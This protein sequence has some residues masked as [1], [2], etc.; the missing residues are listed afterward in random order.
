MTRLVIVA[1]LSAVSALAA[2]TG[3]DTGNPPVIDFGN[4]GC[5]KGITSALQSVD[6]AT[7]DP[8]YEGLTCLTWQHVDEQTV[9]VDLT[10]YESGCHSDTGWTPRTKLREDGGLDLILQDAECSQAGC[11]W[12]IYDLSFTVALDQS[13][14]DGEV[15]V[16]QAG[17]DGVSPHEK[18]AVLALSSQ[19]SGAVCNYANRNALAWPG[20]GV[21]GG[22]RMPCATGSAAGQQ[23]VSCQAGLVCSDLG[24]SVPVEAANAG[25]RCLLAC[26]SDANCDELTSCQDGVC[27]L[28]VRGLS[29]N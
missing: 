14:H 10:N 28:K 4:S 6:K 24:E 2:C 17:C 20:Q 18:W 23:S 25:A 22:N 12:C 19:P 8:R 7:P 26:T 5:K 1:L 9:R 16:Y 27:K 13:I 11:G 21:G 3:T 15:H 29:S